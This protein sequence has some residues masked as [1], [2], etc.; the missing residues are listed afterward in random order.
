MGT[1]QFDRKIFENLRLI[2]LAEGR[3]E[4]VEFVCRDSPP[5]L[6]QHAARRGVGTKQERGS[7]AVRAVTKLPHGAMQE[8][9]GQHCLTVPI[10][11]IRSTHI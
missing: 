5:I 9:L 3:G 2:V 4:N 10:L 8:L 1:P 7:S 11:I 6:E